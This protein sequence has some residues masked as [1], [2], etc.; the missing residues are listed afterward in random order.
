MSRGGKR[1][2]AGRKRLH[3]DGARTIGF[4]LPDTDRELLAAYAQTETTTMSVV[5]RAVV[6]A[7]IDALRIKRKVARRLRAVAK[8]R[9]LT[10]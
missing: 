3:T 9:T 4:V 2:G 5:L 8:P 7:G 1:S 6:R 10:M